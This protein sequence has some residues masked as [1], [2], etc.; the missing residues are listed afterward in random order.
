[1]RQRAHERSADTLAIPSRS[2]ATIRPLKAFRV[3]LRSMM[4]DM[5]LSSSSEVSLAGR[6]AMSGCRYA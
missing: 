2:S 6:D 4:S 3:S 1:M 5:T